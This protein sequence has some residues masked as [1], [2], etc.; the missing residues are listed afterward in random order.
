[1]IILEKKLQKNKK[2]KWIKKKIFFKDE[3]QKKIIFKI[4]N[5]IS[6]KKKNEFKGKSINTLKEKLK[7]PVKDLKKIKH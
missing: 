4:L 2:F 3:W 6:K 7:I 5:K 1:M